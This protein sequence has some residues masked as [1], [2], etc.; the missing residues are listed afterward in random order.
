M[1]APDLEEVLT[2]TLY[3]MK[4]DPYF[5]MWIGSA[6]LKRKVALDLGVEDNHARF[7]ALSP[8]LFNV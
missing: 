2:R 1:V 3:N 6:L 4:I 5:I 7:A 8:V